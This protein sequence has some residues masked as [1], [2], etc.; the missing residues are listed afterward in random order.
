VSNQT[1]GTLAPPSIRVPAAAQALGAP[2]VSS[3]RA[4]PSSRGVTRAKMPGA[5]KTRTPNLPRAKAPV[6]GKAPRAQKAPAPK[7]EKSWLEMNNAQLHH[8]AEKQIQQNTKAELVPFKARGQEITGTEQTVANRY[9]AYGQATQSLLGGLQAGQE[10][11]AKTA[12]NSAAETAIKTQNEVNSAGQNAATLS[13]GYVS[14]QEQGAQAA[15]KANLT[16]LGSAAQTATESQGQNETN[17][18]TNIRAAAAQRVAEGEKGIAST[19]GKERG[20]LGGEEGKLLAKESGDITKYNTELQKNQETE[21]IARAGVGIKE[22]TLKVGERNAATHEAGV[23]GDERGRT[24][25]EQ[26]DRVK[27]ALTERGQTLTHEGNDVAQAKLGPEIAKDKADT[28][29]AQAKAKEELHKTATGG[30]T[31]DQQDKLAEQIGAG[32]QQIQSLREKGIPEARIAEHLSSGYRRVETS[33]GSGKFTSEKLVQV[34]NATLQKAAFELWKYHT[35]SA[36]TQAALGT[37][38]ISLTPQQ[39]AALVGL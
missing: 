19:Y 6:Q 30:V 38:G 34:K 4:Q 25:T 23:R 17:L 1:G 26:D 36:G 10:A 33:P 12:D 22:G 7:A 11:S 27:N 9:N 24:I 13:G 18:L 37:L 31:T 35:V 28:E 32:F 21:K 29:E 8:L 14:P 39:L 16:G 5:P 20:K 2:K 15:M 3:V